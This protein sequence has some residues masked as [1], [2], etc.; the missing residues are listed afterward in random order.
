MAFVGGDG[1]NGLV[2]EPG[3]L[4]RDGVSGVRAHDAFLEY[5]GTSLFCPGASSST[6]SDVS[7]IRDFCHSGNPAIE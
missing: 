5:M 7:I 3:H 6:G 4:G 2:L 1:L